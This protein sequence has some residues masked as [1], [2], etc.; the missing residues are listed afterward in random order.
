MRCTCKRPIKIEKLMQCTC[1]ICERN[2]SA[3]FKVHIMT[4]NTENNTENINSLSL[5]LWKKIFKI[6]VREASYF[7]NACSCSMAVGDPHA[8]FAALSR[9]NS[10]L[11]V[12]PNYNKC[13]NCTFDFNACKQAFLSIIIFENSNGT[14]L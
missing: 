8:S 1:I 10:V 9:K 11:P 13:S 14:I 7:K 6:K 12:I 2:H 5:S 4:E 3:V